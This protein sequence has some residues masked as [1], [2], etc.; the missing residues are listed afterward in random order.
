MLKKISQR[1]SKG[2]D[3]MRTGLCKIASKLQK[4]NDGPLICIGMVR[5]EIDIIDC[6]VMHLLDLFDH[7]I[8]YD[9]LSKDG[10]RERL[11]KYSEK[12]P[13]LQVRAYNEVPRIQS[14]LMTSAFEELSAKF[15]S[16]WLF[17]LDA[18]EFVMVSGKAEMRQ[19]LRAVSRA[20]TIRLKWR[21]AFLPEMPRK[22]R[23][24]SL[25]TGWP[26]EA[27]RVSKAAL[28]LRFS[29][30]VRSVAQGNHSF[31][32]HRKPFFRKIDTFDLLHL[33]IRSREQIL[34]KL[35]KGIS[36]ATPDEVRKGFGA[37]WRFMAKNDVIGRMEFYTFNY[38]VTAA[39]GDPNDLR[40]PPAPTMRVPISSL[41]PIKDH[42]L[43]NGFRNIP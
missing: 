34:H 42:C 23:A 8:I 27:A 39:N 28:N 6:W 2:K 22:V 15:G 7:I 43:G 31:Q 21:N 41:V 25:V 16:G 35:S 20:S 10:T 4:E 5:D 38:G 12:F 19:R 40:T 30:H 24:T 36:T 32:F 33:P 13:N 18:D 37:H 11:G 3:R 9:H 26:N 29:R 14:K 17:F 1:A